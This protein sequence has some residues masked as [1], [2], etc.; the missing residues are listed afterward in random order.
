MINKVQL[1]YVNDVAKRWSTVMQSKDDNEKG[2]WAAVV[3]L[4]T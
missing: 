1:V 3:A 2:C 4:L